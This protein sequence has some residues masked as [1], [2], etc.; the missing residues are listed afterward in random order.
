MDKEGV[1]FID[2]GSHYG[3]VETYVEGLAGILGPHIRGYAVCSLPKLAEKLRAQ[4]MTV[5]CLPILGSKW[6]KALRFLLALL[7]VPYMLLRFGIRTVQ[8][9]GYF[10]SLLL[11]PLRLFGCKT[12]YT[13]HGPLETELYCWY[14]NPERF[15]PR[16]L[17][18]YSLRFASRVVCVSETVGSIARSVIPDEKV[19]VIANWVQVPSCFNHTFSID[20]K[21]KLL[22]VGRLEEYKGVQFILDA[23]RQIPGLSLVVVGDGTY[24]SQLEEAARSLDV[25]FAGFDSDP[26]HFYKDSNVFIHPSLGPEGS[27]LVSLEAMAYGLPCILSDLPVNRE[28]TADG[29]G[30]ALFTRGDSQSLAQK[31]RLLLHDEDRRQSYGVAGRQLIEQKYSLRVAAQ[32]YLT[33]FGLSPLQ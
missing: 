26:S 18:R 7:V 21:P 13:M 22:F 14:R 6:F 10:E 32:E 24:R 31:L 25:H 20:Q 23:M 9:N 19:T 33:T 16:A 29:R 30:A 3:G 12:I 11:G 5:V 17:S 27:S 15:F 28:I 1:L 4:S 2:L 8:L